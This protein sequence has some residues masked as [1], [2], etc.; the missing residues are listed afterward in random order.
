MAHRRD[1]A[2]ALDLCA[3]WGTLLNILQ[4]TPRGIPQA[5]PRY[6]LGGKPQDVPPGVPGGGATPTS[7]VPRGIPRGYTGGYPA[8]P[9]GG[10]TLNAYGRYPGGNFFGTFFATSMAK[11]AGKVT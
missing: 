2:S 6:T 5:P 7:G 9:P 11:E 3:T 8:D 4:G 10:D 1:A